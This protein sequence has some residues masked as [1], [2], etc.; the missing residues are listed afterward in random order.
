M[1][2]CIYID[3]YMYALFESAE[4]LSKRVAATHT[5]THTHKHTHTHTHMHTHMHTHTH[6]HVHFV[7]GHHAFR[8]ASCV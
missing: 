1:Y 2:I 6:T 4:T 3:M 5:H 7:C 8:I